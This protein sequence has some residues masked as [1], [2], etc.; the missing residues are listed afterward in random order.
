[1][2]KPIAI[3]SSATDQDI[4]KY[5]MSEITRFFPRSTSSLALQVLSRRTLCDH[6][7]IPIERWNSYH[8]KTFPTV[9]EH[10]HEQLAAFSNDQFT[11][12]W[13]KRNI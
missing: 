10:I 13:L 2:P 9:A 4:G 6:F 8:M 7:T 3:E 1:M 11:F 12:I 5:R